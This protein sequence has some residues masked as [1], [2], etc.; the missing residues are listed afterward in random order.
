MALEILTT[1]II[2]VLPVAELR[3]AIPFAI[4]NNINPALAYIISVIPNIAIIPVIFLFL[5]YANRHLLKIPIYANLFEKIVRRTRARTTKYIGKYGYLGLTIFVSI[6]LPITGAYTGTLAA[7]VFGMKQKQ[8]F[9]A[10]AIG[11]AI[12]G[13][14]VT[15]A[16]VTGI[17]A[18]RIF[19]LNRFT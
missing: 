11:V 8:A 9:I 2:S 19:V 15:A 4:F 13:I 7:W 10:I 12:A 16:S 6:P 3:G 17:E 14:I 18:L 1:I 5:N